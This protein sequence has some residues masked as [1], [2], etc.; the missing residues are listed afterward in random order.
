M[1]INSNMQVKI[2]STFLHTGWSVVSEAKV[3][4]AVLFMIGSGNFSPR[5][6]A[7]QRSN[8][9]LEHSEHVFQTYY[10]TKTLNLHLSRS[11]NGRLAILIWGHNIIRYGPC[12][13]ISVFHRNEDRRHQRV[14]ICQTTGSQQT[15]I[16][17]TLLMH[18]V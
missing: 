8:F 4:G 9:I 14:K 3:I 11:K 16:V 2:F 5:M 6:N 12:I 15:S 17:Q 18:S 13:A 10:Q 1:K 7:L